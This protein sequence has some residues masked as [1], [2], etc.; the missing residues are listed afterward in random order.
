MQC[1]VVSRSVRYKL[2][3]GLAG[4]WLPATLPL[5]NALRRTAFRQALCMEMTGGQERSLRHAYSAQ[6][7][8]LSFLCQ[9]WAPRL[10]SSRAARFGYGFGM[11]SGTR[12]RRAGCGDVRGRSRR[13]AP[14]VA[15]TRHDTA[16][17]DTAL[18]PVVPVRM[19]AR[20]FMRAV[21]LVCAPFR[22]F[23]RRRHLLELA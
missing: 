15:T 6:G 4:L 14:V 5:L 23:S 17:H 8:R 20:H 9:L 16:R 10:S 18:Y 7:V 11:A 13:V 1:F 19:T 22:P 21:W 12:T 2:H 3:S